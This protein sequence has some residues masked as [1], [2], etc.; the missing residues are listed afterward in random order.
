MIPLRD[1]NPTRTF[2][3]VTFAIIAANLLVFF[4][5]LSLDKALGRDF[6]LAF[7]MTP[8]NQFHP[9]TPLVL[10]TFLTSMF[11]HGGWMHIIGNMWY[12][13]IFGNNI[14]DYMGHFKFLLFYL[15]CGLAAGLSHLI[16]APASTVPTIGASGAISGVLGAYLLLFPKARVMA[17][18]PLFYIM[19]IIYLDARW[20]LLFWIGMQLISGTAS[21]ALSGNS[22]AG[23]VAWFAHIGGF[24][25]G[26]LFLR[27]FARRRARDSWL[28]A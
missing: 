2:P 21:L 8:Y 16:S 11:L 15:T 26:I 10:L 9:E 3:F 28:D 23:G 14:E 19:R 12:L 24:C 25:A 5:E 17:L 6:I 22:A 20:F 27:L 13:W 18:L 4:F 1:E 7:G